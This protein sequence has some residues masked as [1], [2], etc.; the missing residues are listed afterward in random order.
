M[1]E[2]IIRS[3]EFSNEEAVKEVIRI[4]ERFERQAKMAEVAARLDK[5]RWQSRTRQD[6]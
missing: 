5:E 2:K 3:Q 4:G 1:A 6:D